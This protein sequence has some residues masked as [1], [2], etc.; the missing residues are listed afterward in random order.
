MKRSLYIDGSNLFGGMSELL[1]PGHYIDFASLLTVLERDLPLAA[2]HFYATYMR[3]DK[4]VTPTS[5]LIAKAQV[6]FLNSA[7]ACPKVTFHKGYFSGSG[8]EKGIDM[9]LGLDLYIDG[10]HGRYDEAILMSGDADFYYAVK[11]TKELGLPIHMAVFA[12][13]YP[14]GMV[15]LANKKIVYDYRRYFRNQVLPNIRW[16]PYGI[17]IVDITKLVRIRTARS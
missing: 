15:T 13:R 17:K 14:F 10:L 11:R 4:L 6:E 8:K 7:R 16:R 3:T 12:S 1:P 5:R 2:V 9:Q